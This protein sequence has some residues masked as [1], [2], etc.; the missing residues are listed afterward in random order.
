MFTLPQVPQLYQSFGTD[1]YAP[2]FGLEKDD[3]YW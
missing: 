3:M 1:M 2:L